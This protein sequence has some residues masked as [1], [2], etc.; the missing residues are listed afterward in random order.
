MILKGM[1]EK[2][3]RVA[4]DRSAS[5]YSGRAHPAMELW[6]DSHQAI[7]ALD[8]SRGE[9]ELSETLQLLHKGWLS[10]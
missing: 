2:A 7:G 5:C 4:R 6:S 3:R 8:G 1:V 10:W 9:K